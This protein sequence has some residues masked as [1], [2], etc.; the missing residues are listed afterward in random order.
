VQEEYAEQSPLAYHVNF[1]LSYFIKKSN[2]LLEFL[3]SAQK[4][5]SQ[6]PKAK[7]RCTDIILQC[8]K[9]LNLWILQKNYSPT[10]RPRAIDSRSG[11]SQNQGC[12]DYISIEIDVK[13]LGKK[14]HLLIFCELM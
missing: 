5:Y 13:S 4:N 2:R 9:R 10:N 7:T 3:G 14:Q 12:A 1:I 8:K 11:S 6:K